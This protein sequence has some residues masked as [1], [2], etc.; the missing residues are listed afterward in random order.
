[1][2]ANIHK[3]QQ[4]DESFKE[5]IGDWLDMVCW[6]ISEPRIMIVPTHLDM[7][8]N[9]EKSSAVARCQDILERVKSYQEKQA[10]QLQF[11]INELS[12]GATRRDD[13]QNLHWQRKHRPVMS[14]VLIQSADNVRSR[15]SNNIRPVLTLWL[16]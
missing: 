16:S 13:L 11:E 6:R 1:M 5:N 3:Y 7:F 2:V 4:T 15:I 14:S 9:E 10:N 8:A 12:K